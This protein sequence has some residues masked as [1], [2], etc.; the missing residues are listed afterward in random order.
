MKADNDT[1]YSAKERVFYWCNIISPILVGTV[2][3]LLFRSDTYISQT[4]YRLFPWLKNCSLEY[5]EQF[6]WITALC[7]NFLP[8]I[9]WAYALT[10]AVALLWLPERKISWQVLMICIPFEV[11][12][13]LCQKVGFMS[14]TFDWLDIILEICATVLAALIIKAKKE[15]EK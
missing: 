13:E 3:Y 2:A 7:R 8:D 6:P 1:Y 9:L 5:L 11:G 10:Y 14:G 4:L 15:K 12:V